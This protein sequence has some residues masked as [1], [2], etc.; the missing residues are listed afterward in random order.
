M[1]AAALH[2]E[3]TP[4][5]R[6]VS[7]PLQ[8]TERAER[9]M[10]A[11]RRVLARAPRVAKFAAGGAGVTGFAFATQV[12]APAQSA[13]IASLLEQ[14]GTRL[15][16]IEATLGLGKD[17]SAELAKIAE[18]KAAQ[19]D[20][21]GIQEFDFDYFNSLSPELQDSMIACARSGFENPDSGMGAYAIQ[22]DD[23]DVLTPYLDACIRRYHKVGCAKTSACSPH[24]L[25]SRTRADPPHARTPVRT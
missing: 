25:H 4:R 22:P 13:T 12:S 11:F 16:R 2:G 10:H 9:E 1:Q 24:A 23:Y 6:R 20:N 14:I 3:S 19:P 5:A 7:A 18:V 15:D 8:P 17:Y 21:I